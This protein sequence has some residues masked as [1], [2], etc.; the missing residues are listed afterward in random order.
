MTVAAGVVAAAAGHDWVTLVIGSWT[1]KGSVF[2]SVPSGTFWNVNCWPPRTVIVYVQPSA[3]AIGIAARPSTATRQ[4]TATAAIMA[5]R[6]LNTVAYSSREMPRK[7]VPTTITGRLERTL[8]AA[9]ELCNSEPSVWWI[10][11][12]YKHAAT[13]SHCRQAIL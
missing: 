12:R 6:L 5:L 4:P 13:F 7:F 3:D 2:G 8:L 1:G 11:I 10:F 9:A